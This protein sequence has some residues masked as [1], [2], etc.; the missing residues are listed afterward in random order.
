[1]VLNFQ[2]LIEVQSSR[3]GG[4]DV[5]LRN[6][7]Y[8]MTRSIKKVL[9]GFQSVEAVL[10]A[11]DEPVRLTVF[12]TPSSLPEQFSEALTNIELV[13]GE[14]EA[15]SEGTFS[16]QIVDPDAPGSSIDRQGLYEQYGLQPIPVTFFS[17]ETYY[18]YMILDIGGAGQ[19]LYPSGAMT[20]ADVRTTIES[21]LKRST[22]GFLKVVGIWTPP[23]VPTQDMFGQTQQPF[24]SWTL[25]TEYLRGE[26]EVRQVDLSSGEVPAEVDVLVVIGPRNLTDRE[27]FTVDQYLMRGGAVVVAAGNYTIIPDQM[28]GFIALQPL[29]GTLRDLLAH[30]GIQ[31]E[32]SLVM[33]PQNEKFPVFISREVGGF[34]V[35]EVSSADY[36]FFVNIWPDGMSDESPIVSNLPAVTLNWASPLV[37]DEQKNADRDLVV[38]LQSTEAAWLRTDLGIL[39]PDT[40]LPNSGFPVEGEL[41]RQ[42][43]AVSVQGV[44]ESYFQGQVIPAAPEVEGAPPTE[45]TDPVAGV[46]E[47]SPDTARLV[48]IGSSEF[49][50]DVVFNI[51]Q[52]LSQ[53]QYLKSLQFIQ[54][55]V[56][57]SVEDLD[58][59]EIRSRGTHTRMLGPKAEEQR[60]FWEVL[61]YAVALL[62]LAAIAV[63]WNVQRR[64][65]QPMELIPPLEDDFDDTAFMEEEE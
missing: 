8:D 35:Q 42:T 33:D 10:A 39:P 43:L 11:M 20:E 1:V 51:S 63:V 36:P 58:L 62:A 37:I 46:I 3:S 24:T 21:A 41:G 12:I 5:R 34:Q 7:E 64:N 55:A 61:N 29:E 28:T 4:A 18:L 32:Q 14:I 50:D 52:N 60:S 53:D 13:A 59:L 48:V 6:L 40:E 44:F 47:Q 65:E 9:Y 57:W 45:T 22:S 19:L 31:A 30:Y 54:N 2:D 16:Y 17:E 15:D 26:Y 56:D 25:A 38:L 23:A 27:V 49:L